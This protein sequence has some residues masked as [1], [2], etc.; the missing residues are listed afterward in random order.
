MFARIRTVF[1]SLVCLTALLV[2]GCGGGGGTTGG[3]DPTIYFINASADAGGVDWLLNGIVRGLN[4]V[5]LQSSPNFQTIPY[6][7]DANGAYDV[8][9]RENSTGNELDAEN[10]VFEKNT[11]TVMVTMG[12]KNPAPGESLK[13][14]RTQGFAVDRTAPNGNK[15]R[16]YVVHAFVREVGQATPSI[17]FQNAGDNPQFFTGGIQFGNAQMIVVDSGTMD[18]WAK[19]EDA[20]GDVVYASAT[21]TLDPGSVYV[22]MVAGIENDPLPANLP[23]L[24]FIKIPTD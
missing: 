4:F 1:T 16:L 5:Y 11:H 2:C 17:I 14:L 15:A 24:T 9:T 21:T 13:R 3:S 20:S 19:R 22:V 12:L 6:I 10:R 23:S 7:S 8:I 18:W